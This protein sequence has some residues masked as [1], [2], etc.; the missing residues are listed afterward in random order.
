MR[1]A[2]GDASGTGPGLGEGVEESEL[3]LILVAI[4]LKEKRCLG[5]FPRHGSPCLHLSLL[6]LRDSLWG[7]QPQGGPG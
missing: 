3:P 7:I 2:Q 5:V 4:D 6:S 1:I